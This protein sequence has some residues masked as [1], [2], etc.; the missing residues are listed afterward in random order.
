M[1][2]LGIPGWHPDTSIESFYD[3]ATHFRGPRPRP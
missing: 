2:V 3:D 1:P